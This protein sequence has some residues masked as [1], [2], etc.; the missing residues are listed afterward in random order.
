MI[1]YPDPNGLC[2]KA[3]A[4]LHRLGGRGKFEG[5]GQIVAEDLLEAIPI[6]VDEDGILF[7]QVQRD[8][9]GRMSSLMIL[10]GFIHQPDQITGRQAQLHLVFLD[11]GEIQQIID[12]SLL[13][14]QGL[15]TATQ[16]GQHVF[17]HPL[18][19]FFKLLCLAQQADQQTLGDLYIA[20]QGR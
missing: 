8:E 12:Q 13:D 4:D 15:L 9:A 10:D 5:I 1:P 16:H 14:P 18:L 3:H 6:R 11:V 7:G 20:L 17:Q 19:L 2:L